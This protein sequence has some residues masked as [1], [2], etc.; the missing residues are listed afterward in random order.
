MLK[1][2]NITIVIVNHHHIK[3]SKKLDDNIQTK[4]DSKDPKIIVNRREV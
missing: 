2:Y 1:K 4:S 3:K